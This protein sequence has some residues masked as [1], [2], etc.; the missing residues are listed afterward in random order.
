[1]RAKKIKHRFLGLKHSEIDN[2]MMNT[3]FS[4]IFQ[5][6]TVLRRDKLSFCD[7][8]TKSLNEWISNL[9]IMQLGDT[10]KA[11]FAALLELSELECSETLRFDLVQVLHPTIENVLGSLEKNFFNQGVISS[12]RNEHIIE[13]AMLLRCYFAAVYI[14]IV[15]R[16]N[17]QLDQQK[18]SIFALNQKKNLQTARTL[19]TFQSLQQLTQ[20]LYQQHMLYSEPVAGQWLIAHQ[21]YDAA[22]THRYHHTNLDQVHGTSSSL[23]NISQAYAQLILMDIFN[24]NQIRQSEIQALFQCSFD[25]AK[26]VQILPKE[27]DLTKY[28]V[29]TSKDHPPIYNKK[30]SSGFLPNIFISTHSLLDH[31]TATLHKNAEYVS[32]NEKVYLTPA[33]KFHV[34]TILGTIAERRHERYEY[35]AQLHICFGLLTAH[36][37]L[38]KAKNFSETLFLDHSYGLQNESRFMSA[39]DKKNTTE[40]QESAIQ[41]LNRESKTVYQADILDISVNGYRIKWSGDAPKNLRTGEY[42]LVKETSHGHW[43]GGVIRWLKQSSE[44]SLELGLEILAQEIFPCAARIQADLHISNYH[45]VLLLK[46]QNLDETKTTLILPGSQIFRE[47]QAVHLR[48]GKEEVKVYLLNAQLITQS[49]V[50][51]EFELLNDE[52][53]PVLRRFMAQKNLDKIDQDLWEAL[54]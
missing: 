2:T 26:M 53:Q 51:F 36:F 15:R 12:D 9:S 52:E 7:T 11:L 4:D 49:F 48:L 33:L 46:N 16:S 23:G 38:S 27:T 44:K 22:V 41:R 50:Q 31:V 35:N 37:Y 5:I 10:S 6:P 20:L 25:W 3:A 1:M 21:L 17:E 8:N 34:Q 47:H 32:K 29:D 18:F 19:A 24:T 45:P 30:Q 54:K 28:V 40:N 42:I 39:W 43:R 13:L 14:N